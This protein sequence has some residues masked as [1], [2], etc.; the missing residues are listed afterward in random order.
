MKSDPKTLL[1]KNRELIHSELMKVVSHVQREQGEWI[2]H[3]V[4]VEGCDVPFKFKRKGNYQS[5]KGARV[6]ITY[7]PETEMVAGM[8]FEIMKV[9][10]IKRG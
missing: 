1:E 5:L 6:N 7:Y 2:L 9:V 3:S 8:N 4:M 10:R